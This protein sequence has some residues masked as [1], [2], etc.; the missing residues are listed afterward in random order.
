MNSIYDVIAR[1]SGYFADNESTVAPYCDRLPN[2]GIDHDTDMLVMSKSGYLDEIK[3]R[4]D[5]SHFLQCLDADREQT[6][7][8]IKATWYAMPL[9][10]AI[11]VQG[12][13]HKIPHCWGVI[14]YYGLGELTFMPKEHSNNYRKLT[15][16]EQ[17]KMARLSAISMAKW[18]AASQI[19]RIGHGDNR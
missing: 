6:P 2:L 17:L 14:A 18:C 12:H 5:A 15:A 11:A 8:V 3:I 4:A 16:D 10:D 13:L 7:Q 9:E 19:G 1:L